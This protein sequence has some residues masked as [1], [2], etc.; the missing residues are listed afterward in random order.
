MFSVQCSK[1]M[2][3]V[4]AV[5]WQMSSSSVLP[6]AAN[7][8]TRRTAHWGLK[9]QD[10]RLNAQDWRLHRARNLNCIHCD[11]FIAIEKYKN[12]ARTS[13]LHRLPAEP[14][15]CNSTNSKY[16]PVQQNGLYF[17]VT[18]WAW[19]L[20]KVRDSLRITDSLNEYINYKCVCRAAHGFAHVC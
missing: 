17:S 9:T 6:S 18:V 8:C 3:S 20:C 14:S 10:W 4:L 2:C 19:R 13:L 1:D 12:K 7:H 16:P 11:F 15:R 5:Q